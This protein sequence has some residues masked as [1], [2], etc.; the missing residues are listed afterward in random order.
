MLCYTK[1][2]NEAER[3]IRWS[4]WVTLDCNVRS[5]QST[6]DVVVNHRMMVVADHPS[7][8][9]FGIC[10]VRLSVRTLP[11]HGRKEGFDSPTE[12]QNFGGKTLK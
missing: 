3:W 7:V 9:L 1:D 11:F 6:D 2:G 10:S 4:R 12:Y 5:N 8:F